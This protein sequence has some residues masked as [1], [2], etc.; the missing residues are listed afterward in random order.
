[1]IRRSPS[2]TRG[3][4]TTLSNAT[5]CDTRLSWEARGLLAYLLSKP[6]NWVVNVKHLVSE[7]SAAGRDKVYSILKEL[8]T[9]GYLTQERSRDESGHWAEMERVVH[10]MPVDNSSTAYGFAV[11]GT[12]VSGSAVSGK[13][14][15]IVNNEVKQVLNVP[16]TEQ[17]YSSSALVA[18]P[19]SDVPNL[20]SAFTSSPYKDEAYGLCTLLVELMSANGVKCPKTAHSKRWLEAMDQIMRIDGHD[21]LEV[22]RVLRWSQAS[23]FWHSNIL[24]PQKFREKFPTLQVQSR[25][26]SNQP[27]GFNGVREFLE[28]VM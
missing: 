1:M 6:D 14:G 28:E 24:S 4:F 19:Q 27:R 11:Y 12:A 23:P 26:K 8:E 21:P 18:T 9:Y 10:E 25:G 17:E 20:S 16:S 13:G 22:E 2:Q 7:S 3:N 5:L 15:D